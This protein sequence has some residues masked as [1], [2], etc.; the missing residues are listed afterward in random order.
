ME[1][2]AEIKHAI[3]LQHSAFDAFSARSD[4]RLR[5]VAESFD[6]LKDRVEEI[7]AKGA[8]PGTTSGKHDSA[9]TKA[10]ETFMRTGD[11]AG[12]QPLEGKEMGMGTAAAGGAMVPE[13]IAR[14]IISRAIARSP[15][16]GLVRN[17]PVTTSDYVRLVNLRGATASWSSETGTRSE[18]NTPLLRE[19]RPTHGELY[20]Y[21]AVTNWL[22]QDSQF[23]V[24]NFLIENVGDQFG[25][26]LE[27]AILT[28]TGS[29]QPTGILDTTPAL[30]DDQASPE[31]AADAIEF[32]ASLGNDS[33]V[34]A[35]VNPDPL[36]D[37]FFTLK[38]E[39]RAQAQWVMSSSTLAAIRKLKDTTGQY[40]W[41]QNLGSAIDA[42]DGLLLGKPVR[43]S[44]FM[45]SVGTN[46]FPVLVGDW[47]AGY[48]L[49]RIGGLMVVRDEITT[50]GKTKFYIRQRFGG[51]L[52][53]NDSLKALRTTTS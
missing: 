33:P 39:Y 17:T 45:Q 11:K 10:F 43:I 7:E 24:N 51:R 19:V 34:V 35:E 8:S 27:S 23:N 50:P 22:L 14:A 6:A 30:T 37:L 29:D 9:E 40:L 12:L 47:D 32:V 3:D 38:P 20:S 36:I 28:G 48:E 15:L 53:D 4:A 31:R 49:I 2:F 18:T 21:P 16:A 52:T 13:V 41:Q 26:S 44:E 1:Q 25:K 42:P 46:N 5:A